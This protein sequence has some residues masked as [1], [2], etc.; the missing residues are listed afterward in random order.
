MITPARTTRT[1]ES[2]IFIPQR[3]IEFFT[4]LLSLTK[5]CNNVETSLLE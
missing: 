3:Y 2:K 1:P 4:V 5:L